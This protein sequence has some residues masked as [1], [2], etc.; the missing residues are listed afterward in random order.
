MDVAVIGAGVSG[1]TAA[2]ALREHHRVTLYEADPAPGGH[3][4]TVDV[5]GPDGPVPVDTGFIVYNERTYPRFI[6]LLA[7]LGVATQDSDMSFSSTCVACRVAFSS[8]GARGFVPDLATAARPSHWRMLADVLRFYREARQLLDDPT[9]DRRSL[10]AWLED[11][12]FGRAFREHFIVP[13]T[14]AVWSTAADRVAEF[15][16]SYLLRF[17]DNHGLIGLGNSPTWRVVQGGSRVYVERLIEALPS[18]SVRA[19]SPVV[20]VRREPFGVTVRT[21]DG[22]ASRFD[23]V[24]LATHADDA[25]RLLADAD[26]PERGALGAIEYSSN[27]VVLHTDERMLPADPAVRAS[28]NVRTPD[29]RRSADQLTMTY[30]MNRLQS[31]PGPIQ[32]AVSLNPGDQVRPDRVIVARAFRHPMYTF[33]TLDAQAAI[34]ELQGHRRTWYAGAHLG[35]GF[36]EDGC[37]SGYE[38][39]E[40]LDADAI[41]AAA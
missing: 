9:P 41:E 8:R 19:G 4:R 6:G 23:G 18:G 38:A 37:R 33:R 15:P 25:L 30:H 14:S 21:A 17:L 3:V 32:Y 1:L 12:R 36:H 10:G 16:V 20:D 35:Y 7:E 40:L 28:W 24:I 31:L 26:A 2:Y 39:A 22:S 5:D 34:G 11:L 29:C 13:V 27:E